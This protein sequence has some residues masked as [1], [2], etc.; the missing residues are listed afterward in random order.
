MP[1]EKTIYD[2]LNILFNGLLQFYRNYHQY[3]QLNCGDV[4]IKP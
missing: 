2:T 4:G 3:I 1:D